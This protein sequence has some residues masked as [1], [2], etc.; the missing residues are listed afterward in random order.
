MNS[1]AY[2]FDEDTNCNYPETVT[3]TNLPAFAT[4]NPATA[5]FT[6]DYLED[7]NLVGEYVVTIRSEICVP[8]DYTGATCTLMAGEYQFSIFIEPCS[9]TTYID[10]TTVTSIIYNIGAPALTSGFYVFDEAPF[11]NYPETVTLTNLPAFM[12]HS[13]PSS[14]FTIP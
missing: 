7:L 9:V 6:I 12:T 13:E 10:T 8:D 3:V 14:D 5:D 11:C 1:G 2:S 4:H